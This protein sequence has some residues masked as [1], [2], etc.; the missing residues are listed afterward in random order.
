MRTIHVHPSRI[1]ISIGLA[2][3]LWCALSSS[4]FAAVI[5]GPGVAPVTVPSGGFDLDG[6]LQANTPTAD[7]GDWIPGSSGAG[8]NVL[9]SA[10]VAINNSTT[11]HLID[12]YNSSNDDNFAGGK[13][14]NDDPNTWTWVKNPVGDKVDI[15]NALIH[16][17]IDATGHQWAIV[18]GDRRKDSGDAY[19]DFEFLQKTL[20]A[21]GDGTFTSAG[22]EGGRTVN[23]FILTLQL[24][25]GGS[26]ANF[27]VQQWQA[28]GGGNYDYVDITS[29][30]ASGSVFAAVNTADGTPVPYGA[31][32]NTTYAKNTFAEGA[33]D[34]TSLIEHDGCTTLG[35]K[36]IL[37]K[38]KESASDNAGIVDFVTPQQVTLT[39]GTADAGADQTKCSQGESTSFS[40]TGL[41]HPNASAITHME[42]SV[43]SGSVG[44]DS[45]TSCDNCTSLPVTVHINGTGTATLRL[46][47]TDANGCTATDDVVL[48][49]TTGSTYTI[50][51]LTPVVAGTTATF[52][53]PTGMAHWVWTV[54]YNGGADSPD[55]F[56]RQVLCAAGYLR[57]DRTG[58]SRTCVSHA[59]QNAVRGACREAP[60]RSSE[61]FCVLAR[62]NRC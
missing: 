16:I 6:D 47:V 24:T 11:F 30:L 9:T 18:S 54:S 5:V 4:A 42:W 20:T 33:V 61:G 52:S 17:G 37:V 59:R 62:P 27:L 13:K 56:G 51:P 45:A 49:A 7:I 23:D 15:N 39:L 60:R 12:L 44:F 1:F 21:N 22:T 19:I 40:L 38:T 8:G 43:F 57:S 55:G 34:L 31:F 25:K 14:V 3:L 29:T 10:G 35:I 50:T 36:T 53:G 26:S 41:A 32:G 46:S 28:I 58:C 2:A 48:T